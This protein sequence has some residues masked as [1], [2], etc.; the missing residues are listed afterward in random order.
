MLSLFSF[1]KAYHWLNLNN[2]S[3]KDLLHIFKRLSRIINLVVY[4]LNNIQRLCF[5]MD[6]LFNFKII[7]QKLI[8]DF[9]FRDLREQKSIFIKTYIFLAPSIYKSLFCN[10]AC[11]CFVPYF[12][13]H[14]R[15]RLSLVRLLLEQTQVKYHRF[16]LTL[17]YRVH[18]DIKFQEDKAYLQYKIN[19]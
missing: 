13:E 3:L 16:F 8:Q 1:T 5:L 9:S 10:Y 17:I 4:I 2:S 15:F 14:H 6:R 7:V 18:S 11:Q 19:T 12:T